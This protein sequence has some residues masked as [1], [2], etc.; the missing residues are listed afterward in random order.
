MSSQGL[1][2]VSAAVILWL[3][4]AVGGPVHAQD[5]DPTQAG[6]HRTAPVCPG[7]RVADHELQAY[8]V[9]RSLVTFPGLGSHRFIAIARFPGDPHAEI[10]SFSLEQGKVGRNFRRANRLDRKAWARLDPSLKRTRKLW[11]GVNATVIPAPVPLVRRYAETVVEDLDYNLFG[12]NSNTTIQAIANRAAG[13]PVDVFEFRPFRGLGQQHWERVSFRPWLGSDGPPAA[14]LVASAP[15]C[16]MPRHRIQDDGAR[17]AS[18]TV[19]R[20]PGA[21]P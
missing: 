1:P 12:T 7:L 17:L 20:A 16:P 21:N 3:T 13:H 18:R 6:A 4:L 8:L 2:Y 15:L 19:H 9:S 10:I 11:R 14:V 5:V